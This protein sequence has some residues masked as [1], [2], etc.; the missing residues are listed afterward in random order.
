MDKPQVISH[1]EKPV[2][3]SVF[4]VKWI[5]CSAKFVVL[6]SK[7][8]GTGVIEIYELNEEKVELV[9]EIEK[10][11]SF[12]CG[13]FGATSIRDSHIATGDFTGRMSVL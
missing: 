6:G 4:D 7:P 8:N 2:N 5:P 3:Y 1:I 12:R 10:K 13:T 11:S 9:K